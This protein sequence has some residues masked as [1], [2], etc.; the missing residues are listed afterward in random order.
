MVLIGRFFA[1]GMSMDLGMINEKHIQL[2][3]EYRERSAEDV[4]LDMV[5]S[6]SRISSSLMN[7][8]LEILR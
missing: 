5:A 1:R 3:Y 2:L 8:I 6:A 7:V 4:K